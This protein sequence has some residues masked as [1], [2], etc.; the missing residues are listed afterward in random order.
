[1]HVLRAA[2]YWSGLIG[3]QHVSAD[4]ADVGYDRV[5]D[6]DTTK[7][8]DVA[9]AARALIAERAP[10]AEPFF[11]SVG[12]FETHREFFE[13]SSVRDALY[14]R[15]PEN[16]VDTAGDTARHGVVQGQRPIARPGRRDGPQRAARRTASTTTPS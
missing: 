15:P 5:V 14:S 3:E 8:H 16:I 13:P 1:M 12:F 7:V 2:G 11:L 6:V 9:P 10:A 4:P